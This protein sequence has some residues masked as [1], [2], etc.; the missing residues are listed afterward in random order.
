[1][2]SGPVLPC[3]KFAAKEYAAP[4]DAA[5]IATPARIPTKPATFLIAFDLMFII[6]I[7]F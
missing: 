3:F 5:N 4:A 6:N 2:T 7:N 1:L